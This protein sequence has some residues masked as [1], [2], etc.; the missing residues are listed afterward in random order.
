MSEHTQQ[1]G[2]RPTILI[3]FMPLTPKQIMGGTGK[4]KEE[5]SGNC[6]SAFFKFFF[7]FEIWLKLLSWR[8]SRLL[9]RVFRSKN[10]SLTLLPKKRKGLPPG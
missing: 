8:N 9:K 2:H 4:Q 6:T 5:L 1:S 7:F 10:I 3:C